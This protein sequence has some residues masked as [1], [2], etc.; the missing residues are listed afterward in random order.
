[1]R[2]RI[3]CIDLDAFFVEAALKV[4]PEFRGRP[5]AVGSTGS[6]AIVCSAS[7]EARK[8]G[9]K[10][11]TPLWI[12]RQKCPDLVWLPT[13]GNIIELSNAVHERLR[14]FCPLVEPASIDE[15]YLDFTGCD[16][17]YPN[18]LTI[19]EHI[20]REIARDPGLPTTIGFGTNKLMG[21][22]ASS[23][24]KPAGI[25]EILP[26]E[27]QAFVSHLPLDEIPGIG[28]RTV[29]MLNSMGVYEVPDIL[30]IPLTAWQAA[31][32]KVGEY[33]FNC[34]Q[35]IGDTR[36][37]AAENKPVRKS[38]SHSVTLPENTGS[39]SLLL[40]YLSHLVEKTVYKLRSEQLTCGC[41]GVR[42]RFA[43]FASDGHSVKINRSN[44]DRDIF[45]AAVALFNR[46]VKPGIKVRLLG[47][48]LSSLQSGAFTPDLFDSLL[49]EHQ[50]GLN[51]V[52]QI[53]R[54]KYGFS[55]ILRSR[56]AIRISRYD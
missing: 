21:K 11:G 3:A 23:L 27:E 29:P 47:I 12:A 53:I 32:G 30:R 16:R 6:F 52:L 5:V 37:V 28:R 33:I 41:V 54:A 8:F 31:M 44:D 7:Y 36:V 42:L 39:R 46:M 4:H 38:I 20:V 19:A 51:D 2:K 13:P 18:N 17:I 9:I 43:N 56:S 22:I 50:R 24:G 49:P 25:L 45:Q 40:N 35:G 14:E 34:A 55:S 1:M 48:H 26:G 15:F 10:A